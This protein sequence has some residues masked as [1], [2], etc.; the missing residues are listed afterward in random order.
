VNYP[1]E[2]ASIQ[3]FSFYDPPE[4]EGGLPMQFR[5]VYEGP[6]PPEAGDKS[7]P[8]IKHVIRRQFHAQLAEL[9]WQ[10]AHLKGYAQ[11]VY[12]EQKNTTYLDEIANQFRRCGH[13]FVP[14]IR[15]QEGSTCSL[16]ILFLRRDMPGKIVKRGGGDIDNRLKV[17]LDSLQIPISCSGVPDSPGA[18]EDPFF[19]LLEDD[20]LI[21]ELTVTTDR[22][23]VP[24]KVEQGEKVNDVKLVIRVETRVFDVPAVGSFIKK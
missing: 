11:V 13:R 15:E 19:C 12:D 17:L 24:Q 1:A 14:L 23:L 18:D 8:K 6:L 9:W 7:N 21:T 16:E 2:E 4:M 20:G 10:D 3:R 5:L 22:L